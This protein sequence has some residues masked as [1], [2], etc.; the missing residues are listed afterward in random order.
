MN[1]TTYWSILDTPAYSIKSNTICLYIAIGTGLLWY[2]IKKFKKE[3]SEGDKVILLWSTGIFSTLG[4]ISYIIL[5]FF[6]SDT[7]TKM[8]EKMLNSTENHRITGVVSNFERRRGKGSVTIEKFTVDSVHFE[9]TDAKMSEFR[10]FTNTY[11]HV[12]F[13][14]QLVRIT[15]KLIEENNGEILKIELAN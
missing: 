8:T 6:Y 9:Y 13:N 5:T 4:I 14:G 10:N 2:L 7:S 15:Y 12:I 3:N 11:N 1:Y